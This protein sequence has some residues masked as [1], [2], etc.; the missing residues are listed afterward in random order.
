MILLICTR[1]VTVSNVRYYVIKPMDICLALYE[2]YTHHGLSN[3]QTVGCIAMQSSTQSENSRHCTQSPVY[4][5]SVLL[6]LLRLSF[7]LLDLSCDDGLLVVHL[8]TKNPGNVGPWSL[9][10]HKRWI[11]LEE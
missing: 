5:H 9:H 4:L 3:S 1:L 6:R 11:T 7:I 8:E 10:R 2:S